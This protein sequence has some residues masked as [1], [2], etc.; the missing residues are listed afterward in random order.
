MEDLTGIILNA[1]EETRK[2]SEDLR[3]IIPDEVR[4][5]C[6]YFNNFNAHLPYGYMRKFAG[7]QGWLDNPRYSKSG[8]T[9]RQYH[10]D[11]DQAV[12]E[13]EIDMNQIERL[14]QKGKDDLVARGKL[15]KLF[16]PV[17]IRL[18]NAGYSNNDLIG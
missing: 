11:I 1:I 16:I 6:L 4:G 14:Q 15:F 7:E 18:I 12:Q 3:D 2:G 13:E 5:E 9:L 8:R 17:F 10:K